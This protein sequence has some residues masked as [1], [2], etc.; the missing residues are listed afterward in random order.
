MGVGDTEAGEDLANRGLQVLLTKA[1]PG[2]LALPHVDVAQATFTL[3]RDVGDEPNGRFGGEEL[4]DLAVDG[5]VRGN[6]LDERV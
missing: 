5:F 3:D 6:V 1:F 2:C 4:F